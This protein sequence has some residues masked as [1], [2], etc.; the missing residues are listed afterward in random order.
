MI[1]ANVVLNVNA[2]KDIPKVRDLLREHSRLSR[3]EPGCH[4]FEL[5]QS[6]SE[7]KVFLIFERWESTAALDVH[8]TAKG[9]TEIYKP[10][11]LPLVSRVAHLSDLIE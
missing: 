7:P 10:Q 5:Y 1:Y 3:A 6:Q 9:Y 2:E 11:V 8:R 4:R